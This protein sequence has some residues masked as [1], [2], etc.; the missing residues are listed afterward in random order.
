MD[1]ITLEDI[2]ANEK[3]QKLIQHADMTLKQVGYTEHGFRHAGIVAERAGRLLRELGYD[4]RRAQLAEIAGY[5]HDIGNV[6]NRMHHAQHSAHIVLSLLPEMGMDYSEV[7]DIAMA[8]GNHHEGEGDPISDIGAALILADKSDVHYSRVRN[9]DTVAFDIHDR[10]N[11]AAK[12][13]K[14]IVADANTIELSI[15]IDPDISSVMEYFEIFM[16]RMIESRRAT[17]F[18]GKDFQLVINGVRLT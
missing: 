9:P 17:K 3:I 2:R 5:L 11:Y 1:M 14:L 4:E 8:V 10:V 18:L 15:L 12:D 6:V 7:L 16:T 13:S